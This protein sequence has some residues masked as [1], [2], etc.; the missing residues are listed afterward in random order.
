MLCSDCCAS[1]I[2]KDATNHY[3]TVCQKFIKWYGKSSLTPLQYYKWYHYHQVIP[4]PSVLS[5]DVS[6]ASNKDAVDDDDDGKDD[7]KDEP[8]IN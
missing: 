2:T 6:N 1:L 7:E 5:A 3:Q 4:L 8:I